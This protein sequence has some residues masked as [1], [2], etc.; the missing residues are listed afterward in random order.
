MRFC[1]TTAAVRRWLGRTA[2][3]TSESW[4]THFRV[5]TIVAGCCTSAT[6]LAI[7]KTPGSF[8]WDS[9][10]SI[11]PASAVPSYTGK[12]KYL[13]L[14]KYNDYADFGIASGQNKLA[15]LDPLASQD[16]TMYHPGQPVKVMQ[17]VLTVLGPMAGSPIIPAACGNGASIPR[18]S[19][20]SINV[21]L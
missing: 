5:I 9:T 21:P 18:R 14:T 13:I 6:A 15:I 19:I 7:T 2:T 8:G 11:V 20:R 3:C 4:K 10:A 16:D 17:E 1:P 12:S